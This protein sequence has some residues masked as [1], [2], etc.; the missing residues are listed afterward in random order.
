MTR[1]PDEG[2]LRRLVD[3][4]S[5]VAD[6]DRDHVVGCE[7]C[8]A[9]LAAVRAD[10]A[11]VGAALA[12]DVATVDV[13]AAW[14]RLGTRPAAAPN[15]TPMSSRRR[16][17]FLRRPAVAVVAAGA[18][19]A[20]AGVAAAN[21]WVQIFKTETIEPVELTIADLVGLPDLEA[22]G[23]FRTEGTLD[24]HP[25]DG[26]AAAE[27]ATGLDVPEVT[28]LPAGVF[29]DPTFEVGDEVSGT[30][31]YSADDA[32]PE[33]AGSQV[34]FAAGPGVAEVWSNRRGMPVLVVARAVAPTAFSTGASFEAIRDHLLS[35]ADLPP[36]VAAQL[37]T[38]S[39]DGD[40]FPLPVLSD[41]FDTADA[42]VHGHP[43]TVLRSHGGLFAAVVWVDDGVVTTVAGTLSA[44]EVVGIAGGLR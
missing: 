33:L 23:D 15:V 4:P 7:Q 25:V 38:F 42:E 31:T 9:E 20:G 37:R 36:R 43:A 11:L 40:T 18:I 12:V 34:R 41:R 3:E 13:D 30:F 2:V 14:Q 21:D 5:G 32:P 29:G 28:Q 17:S 10:A 8:R 27:A 39:T 35:L 1:H 22:Y 44:D 16:R 6:A 19:L 26:L 24:R